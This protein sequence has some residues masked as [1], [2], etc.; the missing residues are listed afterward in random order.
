MEHD[1]AFHV[2]IAKAVTQ[3]GFRLIVG[4]FERVTRQTWP[5][6]WRSRPPEAEQLK[7]IADPCGAR[8]KRSR[9]AIRRPRPRPDGEHFDESVKA[10]SDGRHRLRAA[11]KITTTRNAP[12]QGAAEP[13]LGAGPYG[14]GPHRAGRDL[15]HRETVE[16]LSARICGAAG[17]RARSL[18]DRPACRRSRRLSRLPLDGRGSARQLRLRHRALGSVRQGHGPADRATPRRLHPAAR[19][20]PTTPAPAPN[21]SRRPRARRPPITASAAGERL[22]RSQRLPAPR[23]RAGAVA[24]GGGHHGHEDLAVRPWPPRRR[25]ACT[26]RRPT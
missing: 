17:D 18:A 4:A 5:I 6:G 24:A 9:P 3:S 21:T 25:A 2:A 12:A 10:L 15:L 1:L 22:R 20:A 11:M 19:S 13:S 26:Y 8:P 16:E 14:R 7:M 23:R